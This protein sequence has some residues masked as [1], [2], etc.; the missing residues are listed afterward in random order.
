[1]LAG[2]FRTALEH[3]DLQGGPVVT[4]R[5]GIDIWIPVSGGSFDR[6]RQWVE[7]LTTAI[8]ASASEL[9]GGDGAVTLDAS[10]NA[11]DALLVAPF[12]VVA[13]PGAPV[14]VP[15]SWDELDDLAPDGWNVHNVDERIATVGDPLAPLI[16]MQQR[17]PTLA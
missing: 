1:M 14:V 5:G 15:V 3:L 6:T 7:Q 17:L 10:R 12:S 8:A 4:G 13:A 9:V 16:G 2:L 11:V